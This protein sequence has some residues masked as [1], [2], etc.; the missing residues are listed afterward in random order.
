M[1][2]DLGTI[3]DYN[4]FASPIIFECETLAI[5]EAIDKDGKNC[6]IISDGNDEVVYKRYI[7]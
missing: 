6:I 4:I 5:D 7:I 1:G 3:H 2:N